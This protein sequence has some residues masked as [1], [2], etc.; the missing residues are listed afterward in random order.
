[1]DIIHTQYKNL[2][3]RDGYTF[4]TDDAKERVRN[5]LYLIY[6]HLERIFIQMWC[7]L[8]CI[9]SSNS[10]W[11]VYE[12]RLRRSQIWQQRSHIECRVILAVVWFRLK[13]WCTNQIPQHQQSAQCSLTPHMHYT[14]IWNKH[15]W[16]K[17]TVSISSRYF[18]F[19]SNNKWF[20]RAYFFKFCKSDDDLTPPGQYC[21]VS[22]DNLSQIVA[23]C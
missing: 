6:G 4:N 5:S 14:N 9:F 2:K 17:Q 1:M 12:I 21:F 13:F 18:I 8:S 19:C 15:I 22:D 23:S 7:I 11:E 20:V 3:G 16:E 10:N